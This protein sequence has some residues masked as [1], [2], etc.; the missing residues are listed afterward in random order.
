MWSLLFSEKQKNIS[1]RSKSV[2]SQQYFHIVLIEQLDVRHIVITSVMRIYL[3]SNVEKLQDFIK[4]L[5]VIILQRHEICIFI[6]K[7]Q[8]TH[9]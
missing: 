7:N 9:T 5:P 6:K 2:L 8:H 1:E 4:F 3:A